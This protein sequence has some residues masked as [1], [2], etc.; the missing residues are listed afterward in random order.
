LSSGSSAWLNGGKSTAGPL[1]TWEE[2]ETTPIQKGNPKG[3]SRANDEGAP[4]CVLYAPS[5][6]AGG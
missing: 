5:G 1:R 3:W 4:Y 2:T 6:T